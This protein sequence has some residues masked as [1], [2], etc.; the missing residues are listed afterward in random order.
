MD[1]DIFYICISYNVLKT[2]FSSTVK[3]ITT[4][5]PITPINT[6]GSPT[7]PSSSNNLCAVSPSSTA[8]MMAIEDD[9]TGNDAICDIVHTC[10]CTYTKRFVEKGQIELCT[11]IS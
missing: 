8:C 10:I 4:T 2:L 1:F 5:L 9:D 6:T 3:S 7:Q 11:Y